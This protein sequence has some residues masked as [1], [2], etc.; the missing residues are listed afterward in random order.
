MSR[1]TATDPSARETGLSLVE[2]LVT[3]CVVVSSIAAVA[4][5]FLLATHAIS[6]AQHA[7]YGT[8]LAAQKMEELRATPLPAGAVDAVDYIDSSGTVLIGAV[9]PRA[10]YER[11][12]TVEP[13]PGPVG[14]AVI[15]VVVARR[16][17]AP[18]VG[19]VRLITLRGRTRSKGD[20]SA[21]T[22]GE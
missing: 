15:K 5:I 3:T 9:S 2:V 6:E 16:N 10:V 18:A 4:H 17:A 19:E 11:H 22:G 1:P 12:W 20:A 21:E 7:T 13:L 14:I 8:V